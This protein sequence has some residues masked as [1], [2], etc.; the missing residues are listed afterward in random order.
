MVAVEEI[1]NLALLVEQLDLGEP[2]T[3]EALIQLLQQR[4]ADQLAA[5]AARDPDQLPT[6]TLVRLRATQREEVTLC[7]SALL[8][9]DAPFVAANI[10][11]GEDDA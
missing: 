4:R 10:E 8:A 9:L 3:R 7:E 11:A 1:Q 5:L 2:D 6:A